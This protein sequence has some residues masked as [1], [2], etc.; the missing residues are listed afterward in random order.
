LQKVDWTIHKQIEKYENIC[1][2][3]LMR[4]YTQKNELPANGDQSGAKIR[5]PNSNSVHRAAVI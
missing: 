5:F 3:L 4:P 2:Q 1:K